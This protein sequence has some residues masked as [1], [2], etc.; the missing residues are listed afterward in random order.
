MSWA[1]PWLWLSPQLSHDLS[2]YGARILGAISLKKKPPEWQSFDWK[3]LHFPNR[4]GIAGGVDKD[5]IGTLG[6]WALGSGFCE[7]GTVTPTA[8]KANPKPRVDRDSEKL[9][10]WNRLGFPSQGSLKVKKRIQNI[11]RPYPAPLFINIGKNRDTPLEEAHLDYEMLIE[12]FTGLADVFVINISSPNTQG[13]RQL[14]DEKNLANLLNHLAPVILKS[15]TPYLLKISP[16][17][18]DSDL[19]TVLRVSMEHGVSG[20]I[21]TNTT[22]SRPR[23]INFPETGGLSGAPLRELSESCLKKTVKFLGPQ[24][25][26]HLIISVGGVLTPEDVMARLD[27]GADLVQTYSALVYQGPYFFRQVNRWMQVSQ[28]KN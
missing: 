20:W 21:L 12:S 9:A 16:D 24:K 23:G 5:A 18:A 25:K 8:Q 17:L 19:E 15:D 11:K 1:K 4:L 13:L 27:M 7:I 10:L 3:G 26:N 6:W 2:P 22:L 28:K 14:L